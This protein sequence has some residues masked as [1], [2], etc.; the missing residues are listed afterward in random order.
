MVVVDLPRRVDEGVAEAL[1]QLDLGLLV[2]PGELR[3]VAAANRV[4]SAVG[5]VLQDL[6]LVVRGPF[7]A[8]LDEQWVADALG[9][10]LA[11]E[12][13]LEAGLLAAQDD[14]AP[15]GTARGPLSRFCT[16]FWDRAL[17]G[18]VVS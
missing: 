16:A 9:L 3:A 18:G 2:V 12:L 15:P 17:A 4:A 5:M 7:A 6:R 10:P 13:P 8:G 11:G 1:A 14:G